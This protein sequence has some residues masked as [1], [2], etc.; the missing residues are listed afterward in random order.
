MVTDRTLPLLR[1]GACALLFVAPLVH[2][3]PVTFF[4]EGSIPNEGIDPDPPAPIF[5]LACGSYNM[6]LSLCGAD[7]F[8]YLT[9]DD[10][11]IATGP[12]YGGGETARYHGS[13]SPYGLVVFAK[14]AD[15]LVAGTFNNVDIEITND[16]TDECLYTGDKFRLTAYS[17][18]GSNYLDAGILRSFDGSAIDDVSL[19]PEDSSKFAGGGGCADVANG[20]CSIRIGDWLADF[21]PFNWRF[22][23]SPFVIPLLTRVPEPPTLSLMVLGLL[24]GGWRRHRGKHDGAASIPRKVKIRD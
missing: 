18:H 6:P 23:R 19:M 8:G 22:Y 24:A 9:I 14:S 10:D 7:I 15:H 11:P 21:T 17:E 20:S 13:G 2:A 3:T 4:F 1:S 16:C 5:V 12:F